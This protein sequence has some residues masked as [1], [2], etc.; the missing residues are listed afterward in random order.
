MR[1][2]SVLVSAGIDLAHALLMI[3]STRARL[4]QRNAQSGIAPAGER[5]RP[6]RNARQTVL[7]LLLVLSPLTVRQA[8]GQNVR[9]KQ[10]ADVYTAAHGLPQRTVP[11]GPEARRVNRI[12]VPV[13]PNTYDDFLE[14]FGEKGGG[15]VLRAVTNQTHVGLQRKPGEIF[16]WARD[17][18]QDPQWSHLLSVLGS[19]RNGG[20]LVAV[21]LEPQELGHLNGWL[22]ARKGDRLY[23]DG[24]C[25][26]WLAN[27]EIA[28]DKP[29]F[30]A[31]GLTRS[32]DGANIQRKL[33]HASNDK[34]GVIGIT[35]D[36]ID[37]FNRMT[38]EQLLGPPP[39][40]GIE[41][42]VR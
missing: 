1:I 28:P 5:L 16:Y 23:C 41:D 33:V 34:V 37:E 18:A 27:A 11:S 31:L 39:A 12:F 15:V 17:K 25:M 2:G 22:E 14:R 10:A 13:L 30:H 36:S 19:H 8:A 40:G 38:N 21:E 9:S 32:R 20:H 42:A 4:Q 6:S 24:N 26:E 3:A 7:A 35:V 29:I